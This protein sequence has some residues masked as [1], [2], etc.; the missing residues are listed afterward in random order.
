MP[1]GARKCHRVTRPRALSVSGFPL[2]S[3]P[4][5]LSQIISPICPISA[6]GSHPAGS[7]VSLFVVLPSS[8]QV[9]STYLIGE[10]CFTRKASTAAFVS[11]RRSSMPS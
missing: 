5:T 9:G 4:G 1:G 11:G 7:L 2:L 3:E 10:L 6:D 8:K